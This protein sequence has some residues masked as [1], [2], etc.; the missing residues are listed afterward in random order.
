MALYINMNKDQKKK[1]P[2]L[3]WCLALSIAVHLTFGLYRSVQ[4]QVDKVEQYNPPIEVADYSK[5]YPKGTKQKEQEK[6]KPDDSPAI[7]ETEDAHNREVDPNAKFLGEH[8]QVAKKEMKAKRVDDFRQKQGSG[9]KNKEQSEDAGATPNGE[10]VKETA[11]A[12]IADDGMGGEQAK[13]GKKFGVK[14]N[15]KTLSLRD[16]GVGGDGG[17]EAATDDIL[18]GVREGEGTVLSTREFRFYSYYHR[19]KELLR[20][21]WKPNVERQITRIWSKGKNINSDEMI[22]RLLVL[23]DET[24]KIQKISKVSGSGFMELDEAAVQAFEKA[25]PFPNPPKGMIDADGFVRIR[26]DFIL[27][28]DTGPAIQ[29]RSQGGVPN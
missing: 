14:R 12:E 21:Y 23:L 11:E 25:G 17:A 7:A 19:L 5:L 29:W 26:W 6:K 4:H 28:T 22:T 18:K 9:A 27:Q 24:G 16:L 15:W 10:N 3:G 13:Q 1:M 20:Q 8:N 2:L